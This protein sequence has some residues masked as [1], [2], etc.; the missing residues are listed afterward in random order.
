MPVRELQQPIPHGSGT[1]RKPPTPELTHLFGRKQIG[2]FGPQ[3][4]RFQC[5]ER[6]V[7]AGDDLELLGRRRL[8]VKSEQPR[9]DRVDCRL[10]LG[11]AHADET[12]K[13]YLCVYPPQ[14]RVMVID[15]YNAIH[16]RFGRPSGNDMST[17]RSPGPSGCRGKRLV[18]TSSGTGPVQP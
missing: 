2:S 9:I 16:A 14:A 17:L 6:R 8:A 18:R 3:L 12:S 4:R 5:L 11:G 10:T 1:S 15:E 7:D 13:P